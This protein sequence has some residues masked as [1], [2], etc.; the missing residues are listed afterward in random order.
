MPYYEDSYYSESS[1]FDIEKENIGHYTIGGYHEVN[2]GD[3]YNDIYRIEK[4]LG[5]GHFST[6]WLASN[7]SSFSY[8]QFL[9]INQIKLSIEDV[10][11]SRKKTN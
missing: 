11:L 4:K 3:T 9:P 7:L 6:V 5:W 10:K 2:I 8:L 1:Q